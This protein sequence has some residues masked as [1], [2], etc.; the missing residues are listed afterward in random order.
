MKYDYI[1]IGAGSAGAILATR[2]SENPDNSV[3]L[4]EGGPDYPNFETL[5]DDVKYGYATGTDL[6]VGDEHDWGYTASVNSADEIA[7]RMIRLPRGK[8]TGGTSAINGQIFLR[9][10]TYDFS[11]WTAHGLNNWNY[12]EVLPYFRKLETDLDFG[13]DFHGKEG[14]IVARRFP[15]DTW[16]EPQRG[17]HQACL[18]RNYRETEDFNLPEATGVG[19]FPCNNPNGIRVSTSLGYLSESRHRMNF[20]LRPNCTVKRLIM[21]K[22]KITG[23]EVESGGDLFQ[24][25]AETVILSAGS[26]AN[27]KILMLSGIGPAE[28]LESCGIKPL[29]NLKG[30]GKNLQD[31]PQNFVHAKVKNLESLDT[32]SPRLQVAL[33]YSSRES[34]LKDDMMMWMGSYAI[35]GDYRDILSSGTSDNKLQVE[36][37]GIQITI[38]LYLATSRGSVTLNPV[39]PNNNPVVNLNLLHTDND[40][41][42]MAE[43]VE[44]ASGIMESSSLEHIVDKRTSPAGDIFKN[45]PLFHKWLRSSTTTGNHLTS[46]CAMG[47]ASNKLAVVDETCRVFGLDNL[48][49][50]DASI[51]PETVRAN[52]NVT[53]MMIGEKLADFL[54]R[55]K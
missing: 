33:R 18:D 39:N 9:G 21:T 22:N 55:K 29:V 27:P 11:N 28:D 13:G 17:F 45:K 43:G 53:T 49:I 24:V 36:V 40:V 42:R 5:P 14:P 46:T 51:M 4:L 12:Q 2:L 26:L 16:T 32:T 6:A 34:K 1:V 31:H 35:N 3:L 25:E 47:I 15:K 20:T 19:A 54:N 7:D 10:L 50:A 8:L 23:V 41:S 38:S 37:T 52:T 44:I 48:Y 30:V